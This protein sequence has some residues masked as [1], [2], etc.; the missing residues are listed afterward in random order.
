MHMQ[1]IS[2]VVNLSWEYAT[3][4]ATLRY[5]FMLDQKLRRVLIYL[6]LC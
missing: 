6:D 5:Y 3:S 2:G 1:D 4:K